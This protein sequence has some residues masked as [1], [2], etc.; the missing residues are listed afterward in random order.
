LPSKEIIDV[1]PLARFH[2]LPEE[3]VALR[4]PTEE[5][6]QLVAAVMN[7]NP[8]IGA[9]VGISEKQGSHA[10][11][12]TSAVV[13]GQSESRAAHNRGNKERESAAHTAFGLRDRIATIVDPD[14]GMSVCLRL[15]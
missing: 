6:R 3:E 12:L 11:R 4:I 15:S 10:G 1:H 9:Y 8:A 14:R 5:E 7:E 2:M 13:L